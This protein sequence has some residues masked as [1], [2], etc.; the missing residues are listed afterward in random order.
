MSV[1]VPAAIA[2]NGSI[3]KG[4]AF[5]WGS[6]SIKTNPGSFFGYLHTL[7]ATY[8]DYLSLPEPQRKFL[9]FRP[10]LLLSLVLLC[11][12]P[13][14]VTGLRI[15]SICPD[16]VF[17]TKLA[18][19]L[20][21]G[22]YE[23]AFEE[24]NLNVYPMI[25]MG[26]NRL[27][28]SWETGGMMWGVLISS[29]VV[30]P[31]YGFARRQFDDTIALVSC[32]LYAVHPIFILWSPELIRDQTFWFLFALSLYL[33]WRAVI[34]VRIGLSL[35]AGMVFTLAVLT[36]FEGLLLLIPLTLWAVWR[37]KAL[38]CGREKAK[39]AAGYVLLVAAFPIL[40]LLL[41]ITW[42]RNYSHWVYARLA[43]LT[44]I[45]YWWDGTFF[46]TA[47]DAAGTIQQSQTGVSFA[48]LIA[49][50]IPA[51]V[52]GF[53]PLFALLMLGG[54]WGWR[55]VWARRDQQPL[56]YTSLA[57]MM[58]AW[59]HAWCARE[60]CER[61]FLPIVLMASLY[62]AL[63][64]LG[65]S[66]RILE[67]VE[68]FNKKWILQYIAVFSP[69]AVVAFA[70]LGVAFC[71][72][73]ERRVAEVELA[74][75]VRQEFGPSAMLFGSEGVTPVVAH[76]A[77]VQYATLTK[78]MDDT[79]VL[80]S[81]QDLKPEV[82]LLLATRRKDLMETRQLIDRI[83]KLGYMELGRDVLP[84][85]TDEVLVVLKRVEIQSQ[86]AVETGVKLILQK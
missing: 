28:L 40:L 1:N 42:L 41:N 55:R 79:T 15:G 49:I 14:A 56:F 71:S 81:I 9:P 2:D 16:G 46:S 35:A 5:G 74:A 18:Q 6:N 3:V 66:R 86:A 36:R 25:L 45:Q 13:R 22:R 30:L 21:E 77:Q 72:S 59:I 64:L 32:L 37:Y 38:N 75:W 12:V 17:Y 31:L 84:H 24:M 20:N 4:R 39:L 63:G 44:L 83:D 78:N 33:S 10:V 48:R 50:Y 52:K 34:E 26:I 51:L 69:A 65:L 80:K 67:F 54:L 8:P 70:G 43:P 27:G 62:A 82:I 53:S 19:A 57:I 76:Y 73:F 29:L 58:A 47:A 11:L 61:Y 60:S 23:Q 7:P 68:R 85:G